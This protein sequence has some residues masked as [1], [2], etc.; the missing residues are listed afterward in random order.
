[1]SSAIVIMCS[2]RVKFK[3]IIIKH[4]SVYQNI[5]FNVHTT[6]NVTLK[7]CEVLPLSRIYDSALVVCKQVIVLPDH[8]FGADWS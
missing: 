6:E 8:L 5:L 3:K 2:L 7:H 4:Q 1:M